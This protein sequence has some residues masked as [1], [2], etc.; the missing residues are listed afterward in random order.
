MK[1]KRN[2]LWAELELDI[3]N[4][5]GCKDP[6]FR[7]KGKW[8][9][10]RGDYMGFKVFSVDGSWVNH[11]L[12]V[13]FGH[14]GHGLVHEFVPKDEIWIASRHQHDCGCKKVRRDRMVSRRF[15]ASTVLHEAVECSMMKRGLNF[16]NAHQEALRQEKLAGILRDPFEEWYDS[17]DQASSGKPR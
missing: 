4:A 8:K 12:S 6:V 11:N 13:I 2:K 17:P 16:W 5:A 15:F 3:Q 9:K 14:G 1:D 7:L 10:R